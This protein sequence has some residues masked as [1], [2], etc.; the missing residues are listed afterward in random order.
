MVSEQAQTQKPY[1]W[2]HRWLPILLMIY[3]VSCD[4]HVMR[5]YFG[6]YLKNEAA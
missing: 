4:S 5:I 2:S 1:F 3:I 6:I